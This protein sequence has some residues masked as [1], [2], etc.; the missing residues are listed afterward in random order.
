MQRK[1]GLIS[2]DS[3]RAVYAALSS[4][5]MRRAYM[6]LHIAAHTYRITGD[7]GGEHAPSGQG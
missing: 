6:S 7:R 5:Q 3:T 2:S 4:G 1:T